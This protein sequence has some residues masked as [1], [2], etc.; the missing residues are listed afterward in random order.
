MSITESIIE[1]ATLDWFKE[2]GYSILYGPGIAPGELLA[3]RASYG[4]VILEGRLRSALANI[5]PSIPSDA[6]DDA[7]RKLTRAIHESPLL[8]ENNHRFHKMFTDGV[9]VEYK[10]DTGRVIGDKVWLADLDNPDNNDWLVVNQ[11]TVVEGQYNRRPDI[12]IFLNGLP[13]GVIELKNPADENATIKDAFNQFQTYKKEIPSLFPYNGIL[14]ASDG[15]EA[16]AGTLTADW[17]WFLPWRT[18]EGKEV[19]PKGLPELEVLI[20]GIFEKQ[21]FLDLLRYFIVFE[22]DGTDITKKMA[23]YHQFHAVNMAVECT[24]QATS[25]KGDKRV[26]VVWHTQGS[27]KSLTMAF[28]AGKI[29]QHPEMQNPTLVVLTDRNDLEPTSRNA[30]ISLITLS[31][32]PFS[33]ALPGVQ[34]CIVKW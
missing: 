25:S 28:Y 22:V 19:A 20:K 12:V 5:N 26:G 15:I 31:T 13:L 34:G 30:L 24:L 6:I 7:Y 23:G 11:F 14:I 10:D 16:R 21:R 4:D 33:F 32:L 9:D 2:L 8:F 27:G 3:E 1:Q 18:I 29:I 17:E